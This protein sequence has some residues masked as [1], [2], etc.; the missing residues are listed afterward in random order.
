MTDSHFAEVEKLISTARQRA[1]QSV[2]TID[3]SQTC[4]YYIS[5]NT[6]H[7]SLRCAPGGLLFCGVC[8]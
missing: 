3:K 1:V 7:A 8:P 4:D 2:N 5:N 6:R